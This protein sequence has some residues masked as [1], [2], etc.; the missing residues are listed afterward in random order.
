MTNV[1]WINSLTDNSGSLWDKLR[2]GGII[3]PGKW[4]GKVSKKRELDI[5]KVRRLDGVRILDNGYFGTAM[6]YT[7]TLW[8]PDQWDTFQT[9]LPTFDPQRPG[10]GRS[11][12]DYYHPAGAV[13]GVGTVYIVEIGIAEP[14]NGMLTIPLELLQWYPRPKPF[15]Q[16]FAGTRQ[17]GAPLNP[18][19][20]KVTPPSGN[21][22]A[23]L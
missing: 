6:S 16:G 1:P 5:V 8:T 13:L 18:A 17:S 10:G 23:N 14:S 15:V 3:F 11:P 19:D 20:F 7:G 12:L 9:I 4:S 2:L 22:G 21:T